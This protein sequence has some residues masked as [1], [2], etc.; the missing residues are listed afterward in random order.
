MDM[1]E[2]NLKFTFIL[3]IFILSFENIC[4]AIE[5]GE[6][7]KIQLPD[8]SI[9]EGQL[10]AYLLNGS[11]NFTSNEFFG[12]QSGPVIDIHSTHPGPGWRLL[13]DVPSLKIVK[14]F[15]KSVCIL[16][17]GNA[18]EALLTNLGPKPLTI[19]SLDSRQLK[20]V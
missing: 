9:Y 10:E 17:G 4:F 15:I 12:S 19:Q 13:D 20:T 14:G 3:I 11:Y 7:V 2:K 5:K 8:S 16:T 1:I 18:K 6:S